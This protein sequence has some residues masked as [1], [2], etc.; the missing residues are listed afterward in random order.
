MIIFIDFIFF[1]KKE[2][3]PKG[4]VQDQ[5]YGPLMRI[6]FIGS[7]PLPQDTKHLVL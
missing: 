2:R 6:I 4:L 1:V 3:E 7:S 5:K